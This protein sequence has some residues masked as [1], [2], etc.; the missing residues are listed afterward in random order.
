MSGPE[1]GR[2]E[3][4]F[5][6]FFGDPT[7]S[8]R[9]GPVPQDP[10]TA[11]GADRPETDPDATR[12][13]EPAPLITPQPTPP[14][15]VPDGWWQNEP[16]PSAPV[17]PAPAPRRGLSAIA[18]VGM[19]VGGV[20][21]GGLCVGGLVMALDGQEQP[22][23]QHT[24]VTATSTPTSE[25]SSPTT[26]PTSSSTPSSTSATRSGQLPQ[27]VTACAGPK[28]GLSVGRGTSVTSCAF[29]SAVRD[30]YLAQDPQ[31]GSASLEVRS[32]VTKK[33]YTMTCSG[34]AVTRCT[35]GNNAV[36]VLY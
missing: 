31:G 2:G 29:A 10:G 33:S 16:P 26:S 28:D 19:L 34:E 21:L 13:I 1:N 14:G 32:P 8:G 7:P 35:G 24:T 6:D 17:P 22:A 3:D 23:A 5:G 9:M 12:P 18:L 30:A 36:V 27:G 4:T 15:A 20:L 11:G 25:S